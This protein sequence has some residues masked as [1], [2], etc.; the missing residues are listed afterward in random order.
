M[1][2]DHRQAGSPAARVRRRRRW[3]LAALLFPLIFCAV[4]GV[5][6][7]LMF[8][9][10]MAFFRPAPAGLAAPPAARVAGGAPARPSGAAWS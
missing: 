5:G 1:G 7:F 8:H 6:V 2:G 3:A 10:Q 4:V 9:R